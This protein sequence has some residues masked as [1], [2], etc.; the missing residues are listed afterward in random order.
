MLGLDPPGVKVRGA[1]GLQAADYLVPGFWIWAK[2]IESLGDIGYDS[3]TMA[4]IGYDWRL[5]FRNM[6][7]RDMIFSKVRE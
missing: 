4:M 5:S 2:V 1:F 6:Q 3:N 7:E